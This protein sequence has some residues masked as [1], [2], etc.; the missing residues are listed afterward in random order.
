MTIRRNQLSAVAL[1]TALLGAVMPSRYSAA[2]DSFGIEDRELKSTILNENRHYLISLPISY[3][4]VAFGQ[5]RYPVLYILDG[6]SLMPLVSA[7]VRFMSDGR[8]RSWQIPDMIMVGVVNVDRT[9][10]M[11]PTR[12]LTTLNGK[13]SDMFDSSGGGKQFLTFLESELVPEIDRQFR[14]VH[15]RTIVGHSFG[16]LSAL[17]ALIDKPE[18]FQAY[19]AIDPS[20]WWDNRYLVRQAIS[21]SERARSIDARVFISAAGLD[22]SH[23]P[24][25][26]RPIWDKSI[27][28][29]AE[30]LATNAT[31]RFSSQ[32]KLYESEDHGS[33]ALL[34]VYDGLLYIFREYRLNYAD[35][36]QGPTH[37][38]VH[39]DRVSKALGFQVLPPGPMID[40]YAFFI[41]K[42]LDEEEKALDLLK[43][44]AQNY[45][46]S[47]FAN[48]RLGDACVLVGDT[49]CAKQYYKRAL[50]LDPGN[51]QLITK[52]STLSGN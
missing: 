38:Q 30:I 24:F 7:I 20:L 19:I 2:Q 17:S 22:V 13:T 3:A 52:S 21:W 16:G 8:N 33:I 27:R 1:A 39:F 46:R 45:P 42:Q 29:F 10:D 35:L 43:L 51:E 44:N 15:F 36:Y 4:D 49:T 18:L 26:R 28:D 11:S 47:V 14:T 37:V 5:R 50:N 25:D 23:G 40:N 41:L 31:T 32:Y 9:R 48:E 6:E 12:S 34:T